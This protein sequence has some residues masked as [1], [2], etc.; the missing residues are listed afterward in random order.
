G[1]RPMRQQ[2]PEDY[3]EVGAV[4][5]VRV[6]AFLRERSRFAGRTAV[7]PVPA[8]RGVEVDD[9]NDFLIATAL[10]RQRLARNKFAALPT[11][12]RAL[13]MDFDGVLTDNRVAVTERGEELVHCHRGDGW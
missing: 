4:Y 12:V 7:Y 1:Y 6:D 2:R 11:P 13:V 10:M 5:A 8:E 9:E 3:L